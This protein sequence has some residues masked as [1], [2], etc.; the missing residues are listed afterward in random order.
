MLISL[1]NNVYPD[2]FNSET[3]FWFKR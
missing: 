1:N 2:R 3:D